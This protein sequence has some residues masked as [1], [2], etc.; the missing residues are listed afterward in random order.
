MQTLSI[1]RS[2]L[3]RRLVVLLLLLFILGFVRID[4][5]NAACEPKECDNAGKL[6]DPPPPEYSCDRFCLIPRPTPT[7]NPRPT[8]E[9]TLPPGT[10]ATPATTPANTPTPVPTSICSIDCNK[11]V[12]VEVSGSCSGSN[13]SQCSP[14]ATTCRNG[15]C[16]KCSN[17]GT[18]CC[19]YCIPQGWGCSGATQDPGAAA[20]T[21]DF[22]NNGV[23][24][25]SEAYYQ[26]NFNIEAGLGNVC[27]AGYW[28]GSRQSYIQNTANNKTLAGCSNISLNNGYAQ[29][30]CTSGPN[31]G[32]AA[33]S[34][35][36]ARFQ[37]DDVYRRL[38]V[39]FVVF[40]PLC[41]P[42]SPQVRL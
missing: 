13:L 41:F 27:P 4:M 21:G 34:T 19:G 17:P 39:I 24:S 18:A 38:C 23:G 32:Q 42:F 7:K 10:T 20:L 1:D 15:K 5:A 31:S 29:V 35:D 37:N 36:A 8:V 16:S 9:P 28:A 6:A 26:V 3:L 14:Q 25:N 30:S 12:C 11:E 2:F 33:Q 22:A 40:E